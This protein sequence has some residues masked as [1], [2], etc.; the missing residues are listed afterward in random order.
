MW[1]CG[2]VPSLYAQQTTQDEDNEEERYSPNP[3]PLSEAERFQL[4]K[5]ADKKANALRDSHRRKR[6]DKWSE[7]DR[8]EYM[9]AK[10]DKII[11]MFAPDYFRKYN[12][13]N[14]V[15]TLQT[16]I[17]SPQYH[18]RKPFYKLSYL[19]DSTKEKVL[20][21]T[22][23]QVDIYVHNGQPKGFIVPCYIMGRLFKSPK[24][25]EGL[26]EEWQK[27]GKKSPYR[28]TTHY[29]KWYKNRLF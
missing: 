11:L 6:L 26:W 18:N 5:E 10:A 20:Y 8:T 16:P 13:N 7:K 24:W 25:E 21:Q 12:R 23:V 15:I 22:L 14:P 3:F 17:R 27:S 19:C 9:K 29:E 2:S 4:I 1:L 28:Y